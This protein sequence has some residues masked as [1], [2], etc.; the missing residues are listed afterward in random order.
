MSTHSFKQC[1][2]YGALLFSGV[3]FVLVASF[4]VVVMVRVAVSVVGVDF[5]LLLSPQ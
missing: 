2:P 3:F 4:F 5:L 1:S